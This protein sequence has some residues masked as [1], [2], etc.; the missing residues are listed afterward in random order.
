M[1]LQKPPQKETHPMDFLN[2]RKTEDKE[3]KNIQGMCPSCYEKEGKEIYL[4]S[5]SGSFTVVCCPECKS[6]YD[7][8]E[9][10]L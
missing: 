3:S 4:V 1:L 2:W 7:K 6:E 8:A 10:G 5:I 9:I